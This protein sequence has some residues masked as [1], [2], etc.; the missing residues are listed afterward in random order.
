MKILFICKHNR[1][2][3]KVAEAI[4]RKLSNDGKNIIDSAG[5][6]LDNLRPHIAENVKRIMEEKGYRLIEGSKILTK[7][8]INNFDLIIIVANNI[9]KSSFDFFNGK[10]I[11]WEIPDADEKEKSRIKEIINEIGNR[12]KNLLKTL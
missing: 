2:R 9:N 1:F 7:K 4:F 6:I 8:E 3:S 5:I 10:I 12:V 11:K